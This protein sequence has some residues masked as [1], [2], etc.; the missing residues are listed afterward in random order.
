[1][2]TGTSRY[3][4]AWNYNTGYTISKHNDEFNGHRAIDYTSPPLTI[5]PYFAAFLNLTLHL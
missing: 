4:S 1:M 5:N 3:F 2:V